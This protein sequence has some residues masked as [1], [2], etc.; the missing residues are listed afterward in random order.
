MIGKT[1]IIVI[2]IRTFMMW[3]VACI[4]YAMGQASDNNNNVT[5]ID[6]HVHVWDAISYFPTM[7]GE[8]N[9]KFQSTLNEL[10]VVIH[11][12]TDPMAGYD[13]LGFDFFT[14]RDPC[15]SVYCYQN[16]SVVQEG[17]IYSVEVNTEKTEIYNLTYYIPPGGATHSLA[18]NI[19][20]FD[21]KGYSTYFCGYGGVQLSYREGSV[22]HLPLGLYC[23]QGTIIGLKQA[24]Q[25]LHL[26][27]GSLSIIIKNHRPMNTLVFSF[28]VYTS[29]C[30]GII[31]SHHQQQHYIF[32][33][34][35]NA[36]S[37]TFM[38]IMY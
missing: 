2:N 36:V 8:V 29:P 27:S 25:P 23:S 33:M 26:G 37:I 22:W 20:T 14:L 3:R 35:S 13:A 32:R 12:D 4:F 7:T 5:F 17:D 21:L 19:T 15:I 31:S 34:F 11:H 6:G 16:V 18:L 9:K 24:A 1:A 10:T 30:R 38:L 28:V